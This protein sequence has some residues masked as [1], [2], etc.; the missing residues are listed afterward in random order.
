M[1]PPRFQPLVASL[2][3][4]AA[5]LPAPPA[6]AAPEPSPSEI[7]VARHLFDEARA[8]E[9]AGRWREA[10]DKFRSAIAIKD[11]P[12]MRFHLARCEEEQGAFVEALVEYDRARELMDAGVKAADVEKLLPGARE[13][14]RAKVAL[15]TIKLPSEVQNAL[16]ELDDKVLSHTAVGE[17]IPANPGKHRITAVAAGRSRFAG[18]VELGVGEVKQL[19][20]EMPEATTAPVLVRA[21]PFEERSAAPAP[22]SAGS[23][24]AKDDPVSAKTIALVGEGALFVA[25]LATGIGFTIAKSSANKDYTDAAS[26]VTDPGGCNEPKSGSKAAQYCP[27]L[28]D[29]IDRRDRDGTIAT[30]GFIGAGVS[31]AA[32]GL[33]LFLWPRG[34]TPATVHARASRDGMSVS[35]SGSF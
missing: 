3:A 12:G 21:T 2:V 34:E 27:A 1:A 13:R 22:V 17:P 35:L 10:A 30:V 29:A 15:L 9:D 25:G 20:L 31:A 16:V 7:S 14:V 4:L 23:P 19:T 18:E 8:A 26:Q 28:L 6:W 32:F 33:T 11:T 5:W 24:P